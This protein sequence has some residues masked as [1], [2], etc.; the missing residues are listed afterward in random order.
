MK[1]L[2]I[3]IGKRFFDELIELMSKN[4]LLNYSVLEILKSH[5]EK[6]GQT[7]DYGFLSVNKNLLVVCVCKEEVYEDFKEQILPFLK[8]VDAYIC[9]SEV[10]EL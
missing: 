8:S 6:H 7:L 2:E 4:E 3:V 9:V 10:E 5:G 1:K